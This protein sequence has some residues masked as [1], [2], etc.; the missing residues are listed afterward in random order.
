M[1]VKEGP[2]IGGRRALFLAGLM[3]LTC[4]NLFNTAMVRVC[5]PS[6]K[7]EY[8]IG[9]SELA[10]VG[11]GFFLPYVVLMP[12]VGRLADLHGRKKVLLAG[13]IL[14]LAG[15]VACFCS[16]TYLGLVLGRILQGVGA[17]GINPLSM[18]TVLAIFPAE[19]LGATLGLWQSSGPFAET[20]GFASAGWVIEVSGWRMTF[21]VTLA[22]GVL[23]ALL[24]RSWVPESGGADSSAGFDWLGTGMLAFGLGLLLLAT[25]SSGQ[26]GSTL[27]RPLI[28]LGV[29]LAVLS[30][31]L[32][33]ET[34]LVPE[35]VRLLNV[36]LLADRSFALAS[37]LAALRMFVIGA[38]YFML[39][40][41]LEEVRGVGPVVVGVI[42]GFSPL[43]VGVG[44]VIGGRLTDLYGPRTLNTVGMAILT[45]AFAL[46]SRI[47]SV[48]SLTYLVFPVLLQG[49]GA[50]LTLVP[51]HHVAGSRFGQQEAGVGFGTYNAIRFLGSAS[52]PAITGTVLAVMLS[53]SAV[54]LSGQAF[55]YSLAYLLLVALTALATALSLL[56]E[57]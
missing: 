9:V 23:A 8:G 56:F 21:C 35:T 50:G 54:D 12:A 14:F 24:V 39:P 26:G 33:L 7:A 10:W 48:G 20:I 28:L 53:R 34:K 49:L 42:L 6:I 51:L 40:L 43:M 30:A 2:S 31:F 25:T 22:L 29:G 36:R 16:P 27:G 45:V 15:T 52:S 4:T 46:L 18:A 38:S 5:T 3:T 17:A 41:F 19:S 57:R 55:A 32:V 1:S 37:F 11:T 13:L 47:T 44:S